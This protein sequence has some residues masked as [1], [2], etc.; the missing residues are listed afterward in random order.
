M[1]AAHL[2][3]GARRPLTWVRLARRARRVGGWR[4]FA[5]AGMVAERVQLE[6]F[7]H[8]HAHFATAAAEVARDAAALAGRDVLR[9]RPRQGRLPRRQR[10]AAATSTRGC[11][12]GGDGVRVQRP[13]PERRPPRPARAVRAQR[14]ADARSSRR[15]SLGPGAL[16]RPSRPEE[17]SRR[18][19]FVPWPRC[20]CLADS[21]SSATV[22]VAPIW[23]RW[24][25]RSGC[26]T[27]STSGVRSPR[28]MWTTPIDAVPWWRSPAA[29]MPTAIATAC[30]PCWWRPWPVRYPSCRPTWWASTSSSTTGSTGVLVAPDDPPAL[31]DA[32]DEMLRDP[33]VAAGMG[34]RGTRPR[35]RGVRP[36]AG[37]GSA[38][39]ACSAR[40]C[41]D[42]D[43]RPVHRS[44]GA[45]PRREGCLDA[46]DVDHIRIR[47]DRARRPTG[48][49]RRTRR[50]APSVSATVHLLP[51]PGRA[52]GLQRELNKL[53]FVE[54]VAHEMDA[55]VRSFSPR[56]DLRA[57]LA[58]RLC[59]YPPRGSRPRLPPRAGGELAAGRG[60]DGVARA[61]TGGARRRAWSGRSC[62]AP[63]SPSL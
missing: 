15:R 29:S 57:T 33:A 39:R 32:I 24:P 34:S 47:R 18:P 22:P 58:L 62:S 59:R 20:R 19:A 10:R 14:V 38:A 60:G 12:H 54:R 56:R 11:D 1:V 51:H 44:R 3:V 50:S 53:A 8:I 26:T 5:Q 17:G 27:V 41:S 46:P 16:R 37:H 35:G 21:R 31:A 13:S 63:I 42:E 4:R 49:C 30:P 52:E 48:G 61:A 55:T 36:G 6:G 28:P 7:H 43:H 25:P 2:R 45:G 23:R 40:R 9:D